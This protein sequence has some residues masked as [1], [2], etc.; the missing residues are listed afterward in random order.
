MRYQNNLDKVIEGLSNLSFV[1][2]IML[3][4][5]KINGNARKDSDIDIAVITKDISKNQEIKILGFSSE[6]FDISIFN[7]LPLIIQFRI[8]RDGKVIFCR[9]EDYYHEVKFNVIRKYLDFAVFINNFYRRIIKN[10]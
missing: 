9:N 1:E 4:G 3:F 6:K 2:A 5:S 7:R 8:I 10:V